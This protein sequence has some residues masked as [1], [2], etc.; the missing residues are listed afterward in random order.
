M[1]ERGVGW[2]VETQRAGFFGV[3]AL[4]AKWLGALTPCECYVSPRLG[5]LVC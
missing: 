2:E 1:K 4:G 3:F 5:F